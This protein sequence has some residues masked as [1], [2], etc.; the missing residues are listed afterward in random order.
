MIYKFSEHPEDKESVLSQL[1]SLRSSIR[2]GSLTKS[3]FDFTDLECETDNEHKKEVCDEYYRGPHHGSF[4]DEGWEIDIEN[5]TEE[6]KSLQM[7][8]LITILIVF[9]EKYF[10]EDIAQF[11]KRIK[12][13]IDLNYIGTNAII[14]TNIQ[15]NTFSDTLDIKNVQIIKFPISTTKSIMW[16]TLV[17]MVKTPYVLVGRS[18]HTFYGKWA[19]LERSIRLL[20]SK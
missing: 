8:D 18:L 15:H 3:K 1:L 5:C 4:H 12:E 17:R 16:L 10:D 14:A 7:K 9:E 6:T 20:G 19:N 13:E 11:A 2:E